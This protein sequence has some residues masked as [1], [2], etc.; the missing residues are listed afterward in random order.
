MKKLSILILLIAG[1]LTLSAQTTVIRPARAGWF[2]T[3]TVLGTGTIPTLNTTTFNITGSTTGDLLYY[4]G[5]KFNQLGIGTSNQYL[6]VSAG[7]I[8]EWYTASGLTAWYDDPLIFNRYTQMTNAV[9]DTV[10]MFRNNRIS[11]IV[12]APGVGKSTCIKRM[13]QHVLHVLKP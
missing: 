9:G 8:P 11:L 7:G 3:L 6:R 1:S 2:S 4:N 10:D 5:T 13:V 12:G